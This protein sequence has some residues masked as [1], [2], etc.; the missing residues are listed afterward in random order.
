MS[1]S[2]I[3]TFISVSDI[4]TFISVS[5]INTFFNSSKRGENDA[6]NKKRENILKISNNPPKHYL[7]DP[8]YGNK[9]HIMKNAWYDLEKK[10]AQ[11]ISIPNYTSTSIELKGG[12]RFNYDLDIMYYDG[13]TLVANIKI[14]FKYG[15]TSIS[16]LPQFL[17]LTVKNC[18]FTTT[19]DEFYYNNWLPKYIDCDDGITE[20]KPS[21][22]DYIKYLTSTKYSVTKFFEQLKTREPFFKKQKNAI[23]NASITDYLNKYGK[24]I[25]I[26]YFSEKVKTT[27]SNKIFILWHNEKFFSDK[28]LEDEMSNI[29]FHRIHRG[30]V[31]ELKSGNIIYK[32]LLRWRNHKGILNPAWQISMKRQV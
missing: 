13:T 24:E 10:I 16:N 18:P 5:D 28:F 15:A 12:R 1:V 14:E 17:S 4:N 21:Q 20:E 31:I 2:D 29:T 3:N 30:N 6:T 32:L 23:V 26:K 8:E 27:Q 19:Y 25:D 11:D 7:E 22:E 9:W